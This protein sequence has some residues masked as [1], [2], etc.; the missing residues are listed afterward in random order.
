MFVNYYFL[1]E[2]NS[3]IILYFPARSDSERL[4]KMKVITD[5]LF[6]YNVGKFP[7]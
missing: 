5:I 4:Y 1:N 3:Y 2:S 6:T 7:Q